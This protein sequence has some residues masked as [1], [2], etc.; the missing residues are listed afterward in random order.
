MIVATWTSTYIVATVKEREVHTRGKGES[1]AIVT[2]SEGVTT[3]F[4]TGAL[5]SITLCKLPC[6]TSNI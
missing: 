4:P 6:G 1:K 5:L 2:V 3:S